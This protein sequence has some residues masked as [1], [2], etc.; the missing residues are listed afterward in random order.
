MLP[1]QVVSNVLD[2]LSLVSITLVAKFCVIAL[3]QINNNVLL[4]ATRLTKVVIVLFTITGKKIKKINNTGQRKILT[5]FS[6]FVSF[7]CFRVL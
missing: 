1:S 4:K 5:V 6:N 3:Q 7:H 2:C